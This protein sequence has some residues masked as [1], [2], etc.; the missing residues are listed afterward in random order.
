M[1]RARN[2]RGKKSR[3]PILLAEDDSE[4]AHEPKPSTFRR[5]HDLVETYGEKGRIAQFRA[6]S[7]PQRISSR[8][9]VPE[10]SWQ[11]Y[12]RTRPPV[13]V[14][15]FGVLG[16]LIATARYLFGIFGP[17]TLF[18]LERNV[19]QKTTR[20]LFMVVV[21]VARNSFSA[22]VN[23]FMITDEKKTLNFLEFPNIYNV[24]KIFIYS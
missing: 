22:T 8:P 16:V 7:A 3:L 17:E 24:C 2:R 6:K 9:I 10:E 23:F 4:I 15:L 14:I 18:E 13:I 19:S 20:L 11:V 12:K 1:F 5:I 21:F